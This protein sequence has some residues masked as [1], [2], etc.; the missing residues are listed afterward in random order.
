MRTVRVFTIVLLRLTV[1]ADRS[2]RPVGPADVSSL[3]GAD[4]TTRTPG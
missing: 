2:W 3:V 1:V 4:E